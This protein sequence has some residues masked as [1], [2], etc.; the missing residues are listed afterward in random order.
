[1]GEDAHRV[2]CPRVRAALLEHRPGPRDA[3]LV[4]HREPAAGGEDLAGVAHEHAVAEH[5]GDLGEGGGEVD[6]AEDPHL[7]RR[8]PAL[9][10]HADDRCVDEVLRR[11]LTL[12]PVV[13][14]ARATGLELGQRVAVDDAIELGVSQRTERIGVGLD[15]QLA[16]DVRA[17][18]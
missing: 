2:A 18:R 13:A 12:G 14:D 6:G 7:G 3:H 5:L 4:G 11:R 15:E 1:M 16:A 10:E 8:C 9:D 17:R